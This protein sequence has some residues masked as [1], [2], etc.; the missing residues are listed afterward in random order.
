MPTDYLLPP[1][2]NAV[3]DAN[4]QV[5][6]TGRPH[7]VPFL[8]TGV[9]FLL[10]GMA[11]GCFDIFGFI[12]P[13]LS[14]PAGFHHSGGFPEFAVIPFF[15]VHLFPFWGSILNMVRLFLVHG[16][17]CYAYT[18]KRLMLRSGFWGTDFKAID[19]D[20]ISE[21]DVTVNPIEN[22]IGVGTI[23]AFSGATNS[24]GVRIYDSFI[25]IDKPY[26]IYKQIKEV[27]VDIKTDWNYPNADRPAAN[28]GYQTRYEKKPASGAS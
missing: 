11:W 5:Y 20:Q 12:L 3:K 25:G 9:I 17:T 4:E 13:M 15:A 6:W 10:F 19:Y 27:S 7:L 23:R 14:K 8:A 18:N 1:E 22:M 24:K 21:L 26:E 28:P 2:F 16:N